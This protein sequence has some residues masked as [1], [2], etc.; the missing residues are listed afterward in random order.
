MQYTN[1]TDIPFVLAVWLAADHGYDLEYD[2]NTISATTLM[3]PTRSIILTRRIMAEQQSIDIVDLVAA[4][5]GS[6]VHTAVEEAW[7]YHRDEAMRRLGVP[8]NVIKR[9]CLNPDPDQPLPDDAIPIYMEQRA[10]K[11]ID[12]WKVSGKFD[13]VWQGTVEDTKTTKT[14]N[15]I[16]GSND[17]KYSLQGSIYRWLNQDIITSDHINVL[18]IFTDWSELKAKA[19]KTYPQKRIIVRKLDLLSIEETESWVR[20]RLAE[21]TRYLDKK[22]EELPLCTPDELWMD[23]PQWAYYKDKTKLARATK[24]F[25]TAAEAQTRLVQDGNTGVV[26]KRDMEPKFC[27]YCPASPV[28]TQAEGYIAQGILK[29]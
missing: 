2:P 12:G 26:V 6:A 25:D 21:L 23:P 8:D 27:R 29:L 11:E 10:S 18:M 15:Y 24:L 16:S 28:C 3:K 22:Q 17:E 13:V 5:L 1:F 9:I 19:D 4:K 7:I 20:N 14:F